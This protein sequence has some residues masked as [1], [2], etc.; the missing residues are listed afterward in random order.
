MMSSKASG[1]IGGAASGAAIGSTF[2]P[3]GTAVGGILGG[4]GGLLGGGDEKAAKQLA[5][6]QARMVTMA[7]N[8]N[9]TQEQYE[10]DAS[11]GMVDAKIYA[12]NILKTGSAAAYATAFNNRLKEQMKWNDAKAVLEKRVIAKG[13]QMA[14]DSIKSASFGQMI[15]SLGSAA[16]TF[17]ASM[18]GMGGNGGFSDG[19]K[20]DDW[21]MNDPFEPGG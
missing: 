12:S 18:G 16:S 14:A 21:A 2:G 8:F 7:R 20:T 13:G 1:A 5:K 3:I 15:G 4:I 11:T 6:E 19:L 17:G 9:R 10:Y